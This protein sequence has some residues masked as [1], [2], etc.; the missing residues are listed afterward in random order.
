[1]EFFA[2]GVVKEAAGLRLLDRLAP[3]GRLPD[4]AAVELLV[5][6]MEAARSVPASLASFLFAQL[7]D[8]IIAGEGP[9]I[10]ARRHFSRTI[11]SDDM[12]LIRRV[13]EAAGGPDGKP[14][15]RGE[16]EALFDLHDATAGGSNDAGF[17]E[18]FY[19]AIAQHLLAASGAPVPHRREALAEGWRPAGLLAAEE[20]AW[21]AGHIMRDGRPT[22]AELKL[23]ALIGREVEDEAIRKLVDCAA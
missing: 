17:A 18:L 16:A 15:S 9:A 19:R 2:D 12:N 6:V 23:L 4:P 21:L 22:T 11:D 3:D 14:V 10:G 7:R 1:V 5:R 13:L 8:A 20:A